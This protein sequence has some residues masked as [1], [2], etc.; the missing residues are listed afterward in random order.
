MRTF[1][2]PDLGEGLHEATLVE[3]HVQVGDQVEV[4]QL[5]VSVE[6]A[7][8]VVD[9]PA[10]F[11]AR[12]ERLGAEPG[13]T[14]KVGQVLVFFDSQDQTEAGQKAAEAASG[15][16]SVVGRLS[17]AAQV[18]VQEEQFKV[19][20]GRTGVARSPSH[21]SSQEIR[22]P[23]SAL[24]PSVLAFAERMQVRPQLQRLVQQAD[25]DPSVIGFA[26]VV[27]LAR[28]AATSPAGGRESV[29]GEPLQ[30]IRKY[31]A[32]ASARSQAEVAAV[33]LWDEV[34]VSEWYGKADIL[35]RAMSALVKAVQSVPLLNA[36]FDTASQCLRC[37][38]SIALGLAVNT[39][40]GLLVPVI[41]DL[42]NKI[43]TPQALRKEVDA[44]VQQAKQRKLA[45]AQM[46]GATISLTNFGTLAGR[47]ATPMIVPP[48]VAIVGLGRIYASPI[49]QQSAGEARVVPGYLL[50]VSLS[51]DHRVAS[52]GEAAAFLS[53]LLQG[54]RGD[55][56]G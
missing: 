56:L 43:Q 17:H 20:A 37:Y 15:S 26:E 29:Q 28:P 33:T 44:L 34:D 38:E 1:S 48:Q 49:V 40:D 31:M 35:L 50:P 55:D 45:P 36:H 8:A 23:V 18:E 42:A 10:P 5:L 22:R 12:I 2:L 4:D 14:V 41:R 24:R 21:T 51:F 19:G 6:T 16:V 53:A 32:E 52:G 11:A 25:A 54:L 9:V 39:E 46:Q 27:A 30:G 3:W 13:D 7:K 47:F